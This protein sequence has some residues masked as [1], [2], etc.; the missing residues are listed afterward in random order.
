MSFIL[1][2]SLKLILISFPLK[3]VVKLSGLLL[4]IFGAMVS[5]SPPVIVTRLAQL[6]N[7]KRLANKKAMY[8]NFFIF[9]YNVVT[10]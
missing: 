4:M 7:N 8:L 1:I 9:F 2:S 6:V 3:L 5:L 10:K